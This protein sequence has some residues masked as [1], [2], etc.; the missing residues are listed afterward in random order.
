MLARCGPVTLLPELLA[1]CDRNH[2]GDRFLV[3]AIHAAAA[4]GDHTGSG[5]T[6]EATAV[7]GVGALGDALGP[8]LDIA[9]DRR[10]RRPV[11]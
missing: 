2:C 10:T 9:I 7:Q 6:V 3:G 4:L 1:A 11:A 5:N 8:G